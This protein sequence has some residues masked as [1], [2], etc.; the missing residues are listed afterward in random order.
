[1]EWLPL[2]GAAP[3]QQRPL[4]VTLPLPRNSIYRN[5]IHLKQLQLSVIGFDEPIVGMGNS[6]ESW[7]HF[8]GLLARHFVGIASTSVRLVGCRTQPAGLVLS[9]VPSIRGTDPCQKT[10]HSGDIITSHALMYQNSS[11]VPR[12]WS[13]CIVIHHNSLQFIIVRRN[14]S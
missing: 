6:D 8:T 12:N 4:Y 2:V 14:S 9:A 13:V 1:M 11:Q 7:S 5:Y 3:G 10:Y